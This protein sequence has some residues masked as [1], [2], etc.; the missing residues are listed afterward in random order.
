MKQL[1]LLLFI[2]PC[3]TANAKNY[4]ISSDSGNDANSG[5][6]AT[7]PWKT[8]NKLNSFTGLLEMQFYSTGEK[9]FMV[10]L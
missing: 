10:Q 8:I 7:T 6:S 5:T 1:F 2:I 4:Y 3:L 9:L